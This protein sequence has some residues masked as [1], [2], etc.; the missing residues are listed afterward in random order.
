MGGGKTELTGPNFGSGVKVADIPEGA[1][2]LGHTD[3]EAVVLVRRGDEAFAIGASCTHYGGPLVEGLVDGDTI[4]CPWHH[5]CFSLRTGEA[6]AATPARLLG[7]CLP[8]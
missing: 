3:G 7:Y 1:P 2:V 6:V 8:S 4:H 5:A